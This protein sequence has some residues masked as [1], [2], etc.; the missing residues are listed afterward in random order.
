MMYILFPETISRIKP[1]L[2]ILFFLLGADSSVI[3]APGQPNF[4]EL[5]K[6]AEFSSISYQS[7]AEIQRFSQQKGYTL[8]DYHTIPEMEISYFLLSNEQQRTQIIAVRGT[9]NV[10]NALLDV[11]LKL[12]MDKHTG[13]RLH[14]GFSQAAEA[15]YN[16]IKPL[17]KTDYR[18]ST[19]GHSLGGAVAV[20]LA[21]RMD[22]DGFKVDQVVSFGQPKL[23]NISGA[24]KF[25]HLNISRVVTPKD[26]VP[27]VPPFDPLDVKNLDIYWHLG[28]EILL[29]KNQDYAILEGLNSML[30]AAN[31][32]QQTP[33]EENLHNHRMTLY[34]DLLD[35]KI[36]AARQVP[37][38]NNLNLF[39]LF[40]ANS[41]R[42]KAL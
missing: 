11:D 32:T 24:Q 30:R 31:F 12:V 39:N 16:E 4:T 13:V 21:M 42:L 8:S 14:K 33:N 18:I 36:P 35:K 15:I 7:R 38:K 3:A 29:L 23:T 17:L 22:I 1:A 5:K 26:M 2:L 34:L 6:Y 40:G 10:E 27:L 28:K 20:I 37:Y 41:H 19:T 9:A 25:Q